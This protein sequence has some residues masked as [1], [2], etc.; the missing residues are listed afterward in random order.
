MPRGCRSACSSSARPVPKR[1]C[2][3]SRS[4]SSACLRRKGVGTAGRLDVAGKMAAAGSKEGEGLMQHKVD[5]QFTRER[6]FEAKR[7]C[8]LLIDTQNYVWNPEVAKRLPY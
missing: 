8:L 6:P 3:R 2:S 4:S 7:T 1:G 5:A